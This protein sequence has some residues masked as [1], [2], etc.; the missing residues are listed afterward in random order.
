MLLTFCAYTIFQAYFGPKTPQQ[1]AGRP[2]QKAPA[3]SLAFAGIAPTL[4]TSTESAA[5]RNAAIDNAVADKTTASKA[6]SDE[7]Q[8]GAA[9]SPDMARLTP[10][11]GALEIQKLDKAIAGNDR[12]EYSYWARLRKGLIQ[13]YVLGELQMRTRQ[14]GPFEWI[15]GIFWPQP[16]QISIYDDVINHMGADAVTAQAA[17]QKGD[18]LWR[19]TTA[20]GRPPTRDAALALEQ[21]IHRGRSSSAFLDLNIF[22]PQ[23]EDLKDGSLRGGDSLNEAQL[24]SQ[25]RAQGFRPVTVRRLESIPQR[26][27][28]YYS[29]TADGGQH[30]LTMRQQRRHR[31]GTQRPVREHTF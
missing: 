12:D 26:V 6:A 29:T 4:E 21:I 28:A 25:T 7:P 23:N 20:N 22:V 24:L 1:Q 17:Y 3:L 16:V 11:T 18:L 13:Q 27:N 14:R 19:Q 5:E 15:T 9:P 8:V 10:E 31:S 30:A 2:D